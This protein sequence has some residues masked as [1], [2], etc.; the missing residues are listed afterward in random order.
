MSGIKLIKAAEKVGLIVNDDKLEYLIISRNNRNYGLEQHI[1]LEGRTNR[2][3]SQFKYPELV[4]TL[5]NQLKTEV[6]SRIQL[7]ANEGCYG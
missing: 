2:K 1:E 4:I 5:D 7:Q 3:V 6:L